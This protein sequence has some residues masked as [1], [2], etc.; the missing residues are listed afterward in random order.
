ME[1]DAEFVVRTQGSTEPLAVPPVAGHSLDTCKFLHISTANTISY[2]L[3]A[4]TAQGQGAGSG[5]SY[6]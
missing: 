3:S 5:A 2:T 1:P 6:P 4:G